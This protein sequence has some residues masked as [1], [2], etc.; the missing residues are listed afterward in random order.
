MASQERTEIDTLI[1]NQANAAAEDLK[2]RFPS[3]TDQIKAVAWLASGHFDPLGVEGGTA[4]RR[5]VI[6][7]RAL[8]EAMGLKYIGSPGGGDHLVPKEFPD[9]AEWSNEHKQ[10]FVRDGVGNIT[11]LGVGA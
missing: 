5:R 8:R 6:F 4:Q 2:W 3:R 1:I 9:N 7:Y 10:Y 11:Y